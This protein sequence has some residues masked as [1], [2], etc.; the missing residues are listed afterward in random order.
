M[1][2]N[3]RANLC[4]GSACLVL[5][6]SFLGVTCPDDEIRELMNGE[7]GNHPA[8]IRLFSRLG[9]EVTEEMSKNTQNNTLAVS[10]LDAKAE[11]DSIY[12]NSN[13]AY[14]KPQDRDH[15]GAVE[16]MRQLHEKVFGKA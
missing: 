4:I 8:V 10:P 1:F 2:V 14:H 13:H 7:A 3:V 15:K 9:K 12:A 5:E 11:I 6:L 16:H